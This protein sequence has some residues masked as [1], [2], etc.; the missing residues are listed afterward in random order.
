MAERTGDAAER[1]TVLAKSINDLLASP[2]LNQKS[3]AV[4]AVDL[5][6]DVF[7][8]HPSGEGLRDIGEEKHVGVRTGSLPAGLSMQGLT[9]GR[10]NVAETSRCRDCRARG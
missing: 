4:A 8:K 10:R 2:A 7:K 3:D 5:E 1:L 9:S 6:R